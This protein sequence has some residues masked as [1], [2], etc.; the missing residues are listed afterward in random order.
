MYPST[1]SKIDTQNMIKYEK[2]ATLLV[3]LEYQFAGSILKRNKCLDVPTP[4]K[5]YLIKFQNLMH[6]ILSCND[7]GRYELVTLDSTLLKTLVL[8]L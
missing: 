1:D 7:G 6:T 5:E 4:E 3:K 8:Q 2:I